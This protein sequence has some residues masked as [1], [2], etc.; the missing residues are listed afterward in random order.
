MPFNYNISSLKTH[1]ESVGGV[2]GCLSGP[3]QV[4]YD[5]LRRHEGAISNVCN[6]ELK[7]LPGWFDYM[8][9]NKM[10]P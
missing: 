6:A 1:I 10:V 7:H 9:V 2:L 5:G 8:K 4:R 3:H